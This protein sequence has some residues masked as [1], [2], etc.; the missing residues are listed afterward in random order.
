MNYHEILKAIVFC[1][2]IFIFVGFFWIFT[3]IFSNNLE[4]FFLWKTAYSNQ[5][6]LA[7]IINNVSNPEIL[8]PA[9]N[10]QIKDLEIDAPS[11]ISVNITDNGSQAKILFEKNSGKKLPIASLTKLMTAVI[12]IENYNSSQEVKISKKAAAQGGL[13]KAGETF[14]T[15]TLVQAMLIGSDNS[16]AYALSEVMD[17]EKFVGLMNAMAEKFE[18]LNT[19]YSDPVGSDTNNYST[20]ED[21][22]KLTKKLLEDYP[23]IFQKTT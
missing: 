11:A 15:D 7:S 14:S 5:S 19:Y 20:A 13:F 21:L 16:A 6:L 3:Q 9:R 8:F 2:I 4:Q 18:L 12:S 23:L 10:W 17:K 1:F 22:A